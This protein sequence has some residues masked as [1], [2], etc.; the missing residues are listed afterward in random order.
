MR[1]VMCI[2]VGDGGSEVVWCYWWERQVGD[3]RDKK[4]GRVRVVRKQV[5]TKD[6]TIFEIY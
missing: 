6:D 4:K 2:V 1:W 5:S 3:D